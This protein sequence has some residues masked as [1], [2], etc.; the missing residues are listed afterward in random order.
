MEIVRLTKRDKIKHLIIWTLI[1]GFTCLVDP[2]PPDKAL[3]LSITGVVLTMLSYMFVYYAHYFYIFPKFYK[4]NLFKLIGYS[5]VTFIILLAIDYTEVY[6]IST[7]FGDPA[8]FEGAPIYELGSVLLIF[9]F[10]IAIMALGAYQNRLSIYNIKS[11]YE[12][13]KIL[14]TKNIGFFQN[15]FN[16]HIIFNFLNYCY[17]TVLKNSQEGGE[18][19]ALFSNMLRHS[20]TNKADEPI[21]LAKEIE[22]ISDYISLHRQLSKSVQVSFEINGDLK[23]K[24]IL[25][26]ILI[27]FIEN[28]FKHGEIHSPEHPVRIKIETYLNSIKLFVENKK[29]RRKEG[30]TTNNN[31]IGHLNVRQ[32]LELFYKDKYNLHISNG[33]ENYLCELSLNTK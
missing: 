13:E 8:E 2:P 23:N 16:S 29:P 22:Y 27:T 20:I 32:Q 21:P 17:G 18:A 25:P 28:A 19:I 3:I 6:Y 30:L 24:Q 15:Q 9:F 14:L 12:R 11:Q 33:N 5:L 1:T 31:G 10:I 26:R 7:M 4:K